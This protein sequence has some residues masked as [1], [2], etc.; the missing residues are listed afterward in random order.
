MRR[1]ASAPSRRL[2]VTGAS[3]GL[4]LALVE[5]LA[6]RPDVEELVGVDTAAA[7][8]D[9]V[10]WRAADVRDPLLSERLAGVGTVVHL[11]VSYDAADEPVERQACNVRGTASV[12]EAC[13][14]AG[15]RR[16][17]L[18]TSVDVYGPRPGRTTAPGRPLTERSPLRAEPDLTLTG[19]LVELE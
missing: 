16:L 2:A 11:A 18:V 8:V 4:G 19:D 6:A 7:A 17:V 5:R 3:S 10:V 15:V 1:R 9:G 12:I 14:A 13:R